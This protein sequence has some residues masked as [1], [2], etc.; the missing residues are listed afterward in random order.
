MS[1][2]PAKII[3]V[4]DVSEGYFCFVFSHTEKCKHFLFISALTPNVGNLGN[5]VPEFIEF[6]KIIRFGDACEG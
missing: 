2:P 3:R 5:N 4:G 1:E 6:T